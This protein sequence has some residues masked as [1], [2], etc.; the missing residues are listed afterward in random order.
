MR[1]GLKW[2]EP[3][4]VDPNDLDILKRNL[5]PEQFN[6][7]KEFHDEEQLFLGQLKDHEK[8]DLP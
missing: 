6:T 1:I 3:T 5:T 8:V 7:L 2:H 4:F